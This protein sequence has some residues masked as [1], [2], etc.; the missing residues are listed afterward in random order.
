MNLLARYYELAHNLTSSN[1]KDILIILKTVRLTFT[2]RSFSVVGPTLWNR[3][4]SHIK[5]SKSLDKFKKNLN[6]L[7]CQQ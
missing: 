5:Y 6:I 7:I 3:L 1:I 4:P 2:S